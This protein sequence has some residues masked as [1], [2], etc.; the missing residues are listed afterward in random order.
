MP[1]YTA[2][3][4]AFSGGKAVE[5]AKKLPP[6]KLPP[7]A[8]KVTPPAEGPPVPSP[9][10]E[11]YDEAIRRSESL[12]PPAEGRERV[13]RVGEIATN[14]NPPET[15]KLYGKDVPYEE[16]QRHR[17]SVLAGSGARDTTPQ[18]AAGRWFGNRPQDMD[19]YIAD[20]DLNTPIY[21]A[22]VPGDVL[23]STNVKNTPYASSSL[24]HDREF[25]LPD[26]WLRRSQRLMSLGAPITAGA[27]YGLTDSKERR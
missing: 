8:R 17:A 19:Y 18:G 26:E 4:K 20:N 24:N 9:Q 10:V 14:Y 23:R 6:P 16:Y 13:Y 21:Y 3:S 11:R 2:W 7:A 27:L 22:D 12:P 5:S 1:D 15:V 25:V